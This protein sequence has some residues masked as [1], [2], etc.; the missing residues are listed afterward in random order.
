MTKKEPIV[1]LE[2]EWVVGLD[3]VTGRRFGWIESEEEINFRKA[4]QIFQREIG[5]KAKIIKFKFEEADSPAISHGN[6][7][8]YVK[9]KAPL[10]ILERIKKK[11]LLVVGGGEK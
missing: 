6:A 7:Y 10:K 2:G 9:V 8:F 4:K 5:R 1:T 11:K 3:R